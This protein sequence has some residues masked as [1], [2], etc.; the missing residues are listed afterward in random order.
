M[1]KQRLLPTRGF[2][3]VHAVEE[4]TAETPPAAHTV[5]V[6]GWVLVASDTAV[7][8]VAVV[9]ADGHDVRTRLRRVDRPDIELRWP[10]HTVVGFQGLVA[11]GDEPSAAAW[12]LEVVTGDGA[13]ARDLGITV[14]DAARAGSP[15]R[16]RRSWRGRP[17]AALSMA[18]RRRRVGVVVPRQARAE[19]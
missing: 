11:V 4:P 1:A 15:T 12:R 13:F 6:K 7:V 16:R 17:A 18:D 8:E 14:D 10:G 5:R 19:W 9:R 3:F 2:P